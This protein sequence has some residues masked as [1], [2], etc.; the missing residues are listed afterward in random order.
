VLAHLARHLLQVIG[1]FI[2]AGG[3]KVLNSFHQMTETRAG[4]ARRIVAMVAIT[5]LRGTIMLAMHHGRR[6][7]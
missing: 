7:A 2:E 3:A 4:L 5:S 1:R 6:R